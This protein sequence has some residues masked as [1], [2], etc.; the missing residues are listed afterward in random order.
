MKRTLYSS[1]LLNV[2]LNCHINAFQLYFLWITWSECISAWNRGAGV[3]FLRLGLSLFDQPVS[4]FLLCVILFCWLKSSS[5]HFVDH[6]SEPQRKSIRDLKRIYNGISRLL[7]DTSISRCFKKSCEWVF[8]LSFISLK[9]SC[10]F[11]VVQQFHWIREFTCFARSLFLVRQI[12]YWIFKEST[13]IRLTQ[14]LN[15]YINFEYDSNYFKSVR[16]SAT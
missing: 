14:A 15:I 7:V 3:Q 5:K 1:Y 4:S 6:I 13:T 11:A 16:I 9:W 2:C 8:F 12:G 10:F